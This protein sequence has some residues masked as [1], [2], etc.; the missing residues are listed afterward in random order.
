MY[1]LVA[2][3]YLQL[4]LRK[5]PR[6]SRK[7]PKNRAVQIILA[8]IENRADQG[9]RC[10]RPRCSRPLCIGVFKHRLP[11]LL[12]TPVK[13]ILWHLMSIKQWQYGTTPFITVYHC[14]DTSEQVVKIGPGSVLQTLNFPV[15]KR[16]SLPQIYFYFFTRIQH[17]RLVSNLMFVKKHTS[18]SLPYFVSV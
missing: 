8:Q 16:E 7:K 18:D 15:E 4:N 6:C 17:H 14:Y 3:T 5:K 13:L 11:D 1:Y 9:S 10:S 12:M 2:R